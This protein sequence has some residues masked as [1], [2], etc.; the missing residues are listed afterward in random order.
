MRWDVFCKVIDNHGDLGVCW[1]LARDLAGR[2][3][4]VRLWVDDDT[5]LR[6]MAPQVDALTGLGQP[7]VQVRAWPL[8]TPVSL[9]PGEPWPD[10]V[11]E[12]FG[13]DPPAAYLQALP[14]DP[15]PVWVNLEYL[16]AEAYVERSHGLPSPVFH[17]PGAGLRKRFFYPGFNA[18]TGGLLRESWVPDRRESVRDGAARKAFLATLGVDWQPGEPVVTLFCYADS[19]VGELMDL[20]PGLNPTGPV[21]LLLTPGHA[22]AQAQPRAAPDGDRA[23]TGLRLH[24]LP[25]LDQ[26][27]FDRLLCSADLNFV[28]G[29]DSAVRALWAGVPHVWQ[30]YRQDDGAHADKLAAFMDH[31]MAPWPATLRAP[32][33]GVWRAW[34]G[35]S[36]GH[37][38]TAPGHGLTAL[39]SLWR[40]EVRALWQENTRISRARQE[41]DGDLTSRLLLFVTGSG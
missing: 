2:G 7:G 6:W 18:R 26:D 12:A 5:A 8:D 10:V 9:A 32:V 13:C 14:R 4:R 20:L 21:H 29:E 36:S 37:D 24:A 31:W 38:G 16:S 33:E 23:R 19:P 11:V 41:T 22:Q 25:H 34:N 3:E 17:G 28:R 15:A 35:L 39:P 40:P 1:R 30:I 27:G